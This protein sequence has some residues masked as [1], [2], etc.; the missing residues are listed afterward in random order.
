M[1]RWMGDVFDK[2]FMDLLGWRLDPERSDVGSTV[3]LLG[4]QVTVNQK[5]ICWAMGEA[6]MLQWTSD[7]VDVL[8]SGSL[9]SG[10]ASTPQGPPLL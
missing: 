3:L 6:K 10:L 9:D 4:L 1:A 8:V 2:V 7:I 5:E